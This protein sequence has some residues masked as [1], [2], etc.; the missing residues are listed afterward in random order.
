MAAPTAASPVA[1]SRSRRPTLPPAVATLR[2]VWSKPAA[3]RA[4]RA[5]L[6]IPALFA[7]THQVIGNL[8]MSTFAA[9]GGFATLVLASFGGTRRD[10]LVAHLGLGLVGSVLLIIGTAVTSS[11]A[12]A[13]LVTLPVV[14]CVLFAGIAGPNAASGATAAL[15]AY[16]LP[17]ASPGTISMIPSRL[18][19]WWLASA[20]GTLAVLILSPRPESDRLRNAAADCAAALS[21]EIDAILMG[22]ATDADT[23]GAIAAKHA[24]MTVFASTPY[25]PIGLASSDQALANLVETLEWCTV[26][27]T[28]MIKEGTDLTSVPQIDRDLLGAASEVLGGVAVV[29]RGGDAPLSLE[30]LE[31]LH[32]A[33]AAR[34]A[35]VGEDESCTE[36][37]VHISFHAR[38]AAAAARSAALD[39]LLT[40]RRADR[41][42]VTAERFRWHGDASPY[43]VG[44]EAWA[45]LRTAGRLAGQHASLRSVWFLNSARG[46]L[47]LAAAVAVADVTNV[48]HGFWVVLGTLSVLRTSAGSTGS[49]ALRALAG[50]A[51]GFFIGAGLIL[52]IGKDTGVLWAV[53]PL[54]IL[55]AAYSP[56][57]APFAVGQAAFTV[58][59]SVLYNIL[60]PV[61]WKVGALRVE[62]VAIGA[63]VSAVVGVLFW[64]RGA[65]AIVADDLADAFHDGGIYL[66][67][68]TSWAVGAR[69][70]RP[71]AGVRAAN[72][73]LRLDDALRSLMAE[74]GTKRVGKEQVW[75]L[76]G[77]TMRL[78]LT[79]QSL[80]SLPEPTTTNDP[81]RRALVE[82][83][84]RLAGWCDGVA[85]QLGRAP[86]TVAQE[87][88]NAVTS[89][90]LP[91]P[92][93]GYLLWVRHH[94]D[95]VK[96]HLT[97]LIEP[98]AV[99]AEARGVPWWR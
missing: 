77:G 38:I 26:V 29:L 37:E 94:L 83:A 85:G 23:E 81:A 35:A 75:R 44:G 59:V 95:H 33:S 43:P 63:A 24:L 90:V 45:T 57:T 84:A 54:A 12:L 65:G 79:A 1:T 15:L 13:A 10:K 28:D 80:S 58:T 36:R 48:Q 92:T 98:I 86:A 50:T 3:F 32:D 7:V 11:T 91:V 69:P 2:P 51:A 76:V 99:V 73:E 49:T 71:D 64:P 78:R 74:Q 27:V 21:H 61:G 17:A 93:W 55:V 88:A 8:Q 62:D 68:A 14:F 82:E 67:Q 39:T 53:L 25:R 89:E 72:A 34:I 70:E 22:K 42:A 5:T 20:A 60:V 9:F 4:A 31:A 66:V 56:G 40:S 41:S 47:A 96:H 46:A 97:D 18:E 87:L 6:V 16:V 52:A 30:R 19:G